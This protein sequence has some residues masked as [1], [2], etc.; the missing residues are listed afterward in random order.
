MCW[1]SRDEPDYNGE[2]TTPRRLKPARSQF[3]FTELAQSHPV[4]P[5]S[6]P[7]LTQCLP[8]LTQS[9][10]VSPRVTQSHPV[11]PRV[12]Q[13]HPVSPRAHPVSPSVSQSHPVSPSVSQSSPSLTQC[14]PESPSLT[15]CPTA[16]WDSGF[17][18]CRFRFKVFMVCSEQLH[19]NYGCL[20]LSGCFG[21]FPEESTEQTTFL[22]CSNTKTENIIDISGNS[23]FQRLQL[24]R[25]VCVC[26]WL[27]VAPPLT[28][29]SVRLSLLAESS[30]CSGSAA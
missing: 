6:S 23:V 24:R 21:S 29:W 4:S 22:L 27:S 1:V 13:S 12:T 10:P 16:Q 2:Q 5:R 7:S 18:R 20:Y 8:K 3:R 14:L 28:L 9:H 17:F 25:A 11:S 26:V 15:Q 19:G 30:P